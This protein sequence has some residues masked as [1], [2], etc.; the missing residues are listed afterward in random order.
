[1]YSIEPLAGRLALLLF[2]DPFTGVEMSDFVADIRDHV[3]K[4]PESTLFVTDMRGMQPWNQDI[5]DKFVW[6]MRMDNPK[7]IANAFLVDGDTPFHDMVL[8]LL[9]EGRN[10]GRQAKTSFSEVRAHLA[11]HLRQDELDALDGLIRAES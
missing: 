1:M 3:R 6:A 2:R 5:Y 9:E 4:A 7:V 10:E 8:R 11:P